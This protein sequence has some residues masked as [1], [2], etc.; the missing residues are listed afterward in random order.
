MFKKTYKNRK[1]EHKKAYAAIHTVVLNQP[2]F[3]S[4]ISSIRSCSQNTGP[5]IVTKRLKLVVIVG[6]ES[7]SLEDNNVIDWSFLRE[8][9]GVELEPVVGVVSEDEAAGLG[10]KGGRDEESKSWGR[11]EIAGEDNELVDDDNNDGLRLDDVGDGGG[12]GF[13]RDVIIFVA[14]RRSLLTWALISRV[15]DIARRRVALTGTSMYSRVVIV[16]SGTW[17][18]SVTALFTQ[19]FTWP[20]ETNDAHCP[21]SSISESVSR[22]LALN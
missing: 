16:L 21:V 11:R 22:I 15:S 3:H 20:Y 13:G 14:G 12:D 4:M 17:N 18:R 2:R 5:M 1:S 6:I 8:F 10:D 9:W 19:H 7:G